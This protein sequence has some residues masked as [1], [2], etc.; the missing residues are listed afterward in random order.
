MET[1]GGGWGREEGIYLEG[2][3]RGEE[4]VERKARM[5]IKEWKGKERK[6][7]GD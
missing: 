2:S 4:G 6:G 7:K 1:G 3:E 5:T